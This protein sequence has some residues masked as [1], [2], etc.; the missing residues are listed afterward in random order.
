MVRRRVN[1]LELLLIPLGFAVGAYGT[2]VGAGGGFV[3]VPVLLHPLPRRGSG[4]DHLDLARRRLLQRAFGFGRLRAP[5]AHR[6]LHRP[7]L[8]RRRTA[9][10]YRRRTPRERR[11]AQSLR[12][13]LRRPALRAR[14]LHAL[15]FRPHRRDPRAASR[16]RRRHAG[17]ARSTTKAR[18]SATPTTSGRASL[19]APSSASSPACSASAAA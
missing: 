15:G 5:Q 9:G 4:G 10:R 16:P 11:T 18:S 2:L 14:R 3:L 8:R 12:R 13:H 19:T 6:L 1:W 7:H 17:D